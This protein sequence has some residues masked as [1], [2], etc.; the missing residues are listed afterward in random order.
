MKLVPSTKYYSYYYYYYKNGAT[1]IIKNYIIFLK[2]KAN[3]IRT[4]RW[5]GAGK[6]RAIRYTSSFRSTSMT[7]R[8]TLR[9]TSKRATRRQ[10]MYSHEVKYKHYILHN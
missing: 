3:Q 10:I 4:N 9:G 2:E 5:S 8:T 6:Q 7:R 1:A